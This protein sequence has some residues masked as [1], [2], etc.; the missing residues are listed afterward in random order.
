M[1]RFEVPEW[2][3]KIESFLT[4]ARRLGFGENDASNSPHAGLGGEGATDASKSFKS[5]ML[6]VLI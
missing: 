5:N 4:G 3:R 1:R 6:P 2:R